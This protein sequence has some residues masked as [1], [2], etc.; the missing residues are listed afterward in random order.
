MDALRVIAT[1]LDGTLLGPEGALSGRTLAALGAAREAGIAVVAVTARPPRVFAE[2]TA[3]AGALEAAICANGAIVYDPA[4]GAII[5][6]R[7]L[8]A[9]TVAL[10]AKT[11]RAALPHLRFGVESG[12]AV[13]AEPGY[14]KVDSAGDRRIYCDTF[15]AALAQAP[16]VVKLLAH[17]E[18]GEA[19]LLL[20]AARGLDLAG[21]T[22]SHSGGEG[23][24]ELGPARVS[25]AEALASWCAD[26]GVGPEGVVAFGD[27]PNDVPML[28][29]A[30]R[31]FA[32]AN[33]HPEAVAAATGR[34]GSN[35]DDGV[36][37]EIEDLL[38]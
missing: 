16:Q 26:R 17:V 1:D 35:V 11:L 27:A 15:E 7:T 23:L 33:A 9:E 14:A 10:V 32:V 18:G 5:A 34:C 29:W 6:S 22:L 4:Q 30:G 2:W 24:L 21:V 25:K 20:A 8:P 12:F 38:C 28:A 19:D 37:A 36:A 31:S 13:F 3:L